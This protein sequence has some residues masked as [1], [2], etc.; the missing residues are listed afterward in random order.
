MLRIR[1]PF[2]NSFLSLLGWTENTHVTRRN[3]YDT[4]GETPQSHNQG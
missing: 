3:E 1:N 4:Q 2:L